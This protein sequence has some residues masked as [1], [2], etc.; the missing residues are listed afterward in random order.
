LRIDSC[1]I[2]GIRLSHFIQT[3]FM[4]K[5]IY[6]RLKAPVAAVTR[7]IQATVPTTPMLIGETCPMAA[8]LVALGDAELDDGEPLEDAGTD[9]VLSLRFANK[10]SFT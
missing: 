5:T 6:S 8:F 9:D 10:A 7:T 4:C 2:I 3:L 1:D